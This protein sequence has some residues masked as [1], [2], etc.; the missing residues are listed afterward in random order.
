MSVSTASGRCSATA[1]SS[2]CGS[3]TVVDQLDVVGLGQQRSHALADQVVVVGENDPQAMVRQRR[4]ATSGERSGTLWRTQRSPAALVSGRASPDGDGSCRLRRASA[5]SGVP[6]VTHLAAQLLLV[7]A[8]Q[9]EGGGGRVAEHGGLPRSVGW[10][11]L[12]G[13]CASVRYAGQNGSR[14]P[15]GVRRSRGAGT[16]RLVWVVICCCRTVVLLSWLRCSVFVELCSVVPCFDV[17]SDRSARR[18]RCHPIP[19]GSLARWGWG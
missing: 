9:L 13:G 1:F 11:D 14:R 2:E 12:W 4:P 16:G 5:A 7:Q 15:V 8:E 17:R 6:R 10:G 18:P 3:A 19:R